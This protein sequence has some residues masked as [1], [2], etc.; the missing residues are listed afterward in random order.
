MALNSYDQIQLDKAIFLIQTHMIVNNQSFK[1]NF[2]S[3]S[4]AFVK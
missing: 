2:S 1:P 3:L 4:S